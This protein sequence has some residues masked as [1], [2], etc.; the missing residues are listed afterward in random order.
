MN[1]SLKLQAQKSQLG[2]WLYLMT[3]AMLFAS[4]FATFMVLRH[5]TNGGVS[6]QEIFSLPY[7]MVET[8]L[9]LTSSLTCGIANLALRAGKLQLFRW[10]LALTLALGAAFLGMELIEFDKLIREGNSWT[11]S[12]FLSAYFSLVGLHG[13]HIAVGL[14]WGLLLGWMV[15][16]SGNNEHL[17]RKF[18]L[19]TLFWHFLDIVWI[20][21]F[22]IVYVLGVVS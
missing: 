17:R 11:S 12:A 13:L 20:F 5:A 4:F 8:V 21:I 16:R 10:L 22:T 7:V 2:F 18:G 9:L 14:L 19:F 6:S 1:A 3:D 15:T